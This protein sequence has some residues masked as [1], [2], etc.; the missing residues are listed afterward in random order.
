MI[1][2]STSCLFLSMSM[3]DHKHRF[4][5]LQEHY[6]SLK[7]ENEELQKT[8]RNLTSIISDAAGQPS[9]GPQSTKDSSASQQTKAKAPL[10]I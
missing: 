6:I 10:M 5:Q 3:L 7:K 1:I 4:E 2:L 9:D 8:L